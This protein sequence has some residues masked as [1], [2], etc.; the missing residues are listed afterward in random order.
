MRSRR[1][2][3]AGL[4]AWAVAIVLALAVTACAEQGQTVPGTPAPFGETPGEF[5]PQTPLIDPG[6]PAP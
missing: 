5:A 2:N 6:Q 4:V 3:L 1:A